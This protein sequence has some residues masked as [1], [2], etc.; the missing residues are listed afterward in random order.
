MGTWKQTLLSI[1]G[2]LKKEPGYV[3]F[4]YPVNPT[5]LH[6]PLYPFLIRTPMDLGTVEAKL[7]SN[8]YTSA[9]DAGIDIMVCFNNALLFNGPASTGSD[10]YKAA[11]CMRS[12]VCKQWKS[13]FQ[14]DA[15]RVSFHI[16]VPNDIAEHE[17]V[18]LSD[19]NIAIL[20]DMISRMKKKFEKALEPFIYCV[21]P[22]RYPD[23]YENVSD[24]IALSVV[25]A[26]LELHGYDTAGHFAG[27]VRRIWNNCILYNGH[28]KLSRQAGKL[29]AKFEKYFSKA[30]S[31]MGSSVVVIDDVSPKSAQKLPPI[32]LIPPTAQDP[33]PI[34]SPIEVSTPITL[35][36]TIPQ[37]SIQKSV[38]LNIVNKLIK[39]KRSQIFRDPVPDSVVGYK[40]TISRPMDLRTVKSNIQKDLYISDHDF[41]ADVTQIWENCR[42]FNGPSPIVDLANTLSQKF[43]RDLLPLLGPAVSAPVIMAPPA[44]P[45]LADTDAGVPITKVSSPVFV[46]SDDTA[47]VQVK[48]VAELSSAND[49]GRVSADPIAIEDVSAV[50][51][52]LGIKAAA[53]PESKDPALPPALPSLTLLSNS[54]VPSSSPMTP[55]RSQT[56]VVDSSASFIPSMPMTRSSSRLCSGILRSVCALELSGDFMDP[57]DPALYNYV[58]YDNYV[59]TRMDLKTVRK[60]LDADRYPTPNDFVSDV[61]LVFLNALRYPGTPILTKIASRFLLFHVETSFLEAFPG[62]FA[63]SNRDQPWVGAAKSALAE[64]GVF[65]YGRLFA[66]PVN[67]IIFNLVEYY[68]RVSSPR[69]LQTINRKLDAGVY[70]SIEHFL[71]DVDLIWANCCAYHGETNRELSEVAINCRSV[72]LEAFERASRLVL[73][74]LHVEPISVDAPAPVTKPTPKRPAPTP[75]VHLIRRLKKMD[76]Q[77][78][79]HFPV[80][81]TL[82]PEYVNFCPQPM[83]LG[84]VEAR[85]LDGYYETAE[86]YVADVRLI[87]SNCAA[88]NAEGTLI[89]TLGDRMSVIFEA[90]LEKVDIQASL[91][92]IKAKAEHK[93]QLKAQKEKVREDKRLQVVQKAAKQNTSELK[94]PRPA[95]SLEL[96]LES[97]S[98][99]LGKHSKMPASLPKKFLKKPPHPSPGEE[100]VFKTLPPRVPMSAMMRRKIVP[101]IRA[102]VQALRL[103][104]SSI[105]TSSS[106]ESKK[107]NDSGS[108]VQQSTDLLAPGS[109]GIKLR[110]GPQS[111][112]RPNGS[113]FRNCKSNSSIFF[114]FAKSD[115]MDIDPSPNNVPEDVVVCSKDPCFPTSMIEDSALNLPL[116]LPN[117][118]IYMHGCSTMAFTLALPRSAIDSAT[119]RALGLRRLHPDTPVSYQ[120]RRLNF[121]IEGIPVEVLYLVLHSEEIVSSQLQI[122]ISPL[123]GKEW[124]SL[125]RVISDLEH[126]QAML[127]RRDAF[128]ALCEPLTE[129][130]TTLMLPALPTA[131]SLQWFKQGFYLAQSSVGNVDPRASLHIIGMQGSFAV[132]IDGISI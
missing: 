70:A 15:P 6:I 108:L 127:K 52:G 115:A 68:D 9:S 92:E 106:D 54:T 83:D 95:Q 124:Q 16:N 11:K 114:S 18:P 121:Y 81:Q 91:N 103:T 104:P 119:R 100:L 60:N 110:F 93:R 44:T 131:S 71:S 111:K 80:D 98:P 24:P 41:I 34:S 107:E 50:K 35:K 42:I 94:R 31:D 7:S 75:S 48:S 30:L 13:K 56:A 27:E 26:K 40:Q 38:C 29:S 32:V 126:A 1:L 129:A 101:V 4:K 72:F 125:I 43:E 65:D 36:L 73:S 67:P 39:D 78:I 5:E 69:D 77:Q 19:A 17:K 2:R 66:E 64:V 59:S 116:A 112:V 46:K 10:V 62:E 55:A 84:T 3:Y 57:L 123:S 8:E 63:K 113:K 14:E 82:Y 23:Y 51:E 88:Y 130:D 90:N 74:D 109:N 25:E 117:R 45:S 118:D 97:S 53:A 28:D 122:S 132:S 96:T 47:S 79:F 58:G 37:T 49:M 61:N 12:L 85:L 128:D 86:K 120:L 102:K 76:S 89:R 22:E 20:M 87:F 21:D 33:K 105:L 99:L